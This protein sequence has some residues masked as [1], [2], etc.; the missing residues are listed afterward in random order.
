MPTLI[1]MFMCDIW[2]AAHDRYKESKQ[3]EL[4]RKQFL[5]EVTVIKYEEAHWDSLKQKEAQ[6]GNC[7]PAP[8]NGGKRAK[9]SSKKQRDALFNWAQEFKR[10]FF[11]W[12]TTKKRVQKDFA[13]VMVKR[14]TM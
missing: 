1:D 10:I 14:V 8:G 13:T 9:F 2:H 7:C 11:L 5:K 12:R 6:G 3:Q 4:T